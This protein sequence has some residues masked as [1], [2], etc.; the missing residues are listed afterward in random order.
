MAS[1]ET[2]LQA[3]KVAE[4]RDKTLR[5]PMASRCR[6]SHMTRPAIQASISQ[7]LSKRSPTPVW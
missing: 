1:V 2:L 6:P 5:R 7:P 4:S 3:V